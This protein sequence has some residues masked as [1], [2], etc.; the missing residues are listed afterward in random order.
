MR[1]RSN[2]ST[3]VLL[4]LQFCTI[5]CTAFRYRQ[6]L[7]VCFCAVSRERSRALRQCQCQA[8]A[9]LLRR[10]LAHSKA[11]R[12]RRASQLCRFPRMCDI[13]RRASSAVAA[14]AASERRRPEKQKLAA[15]AARREDATVTSRPLESRRPT[16]SP[17]QASIVENEPTRKYQK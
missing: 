16:R 6:L 14:A 13:R 11:R 15:A 1:A 5:Y 7:S 8:R 10:S 4:M 9:P 12:R 17:P 3:A 2:S